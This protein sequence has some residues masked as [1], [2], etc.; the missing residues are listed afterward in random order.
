MKE[1]ILTP[2][3]SSSYMTPGGTEVLSQ[4]PTSN[5]AWKKTPRPFWKESILKLNV[6]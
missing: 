1:T 5:Y 2:L 4:E 3:F 6:A